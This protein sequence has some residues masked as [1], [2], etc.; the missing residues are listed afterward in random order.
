MA[1]VRKKAL[2]NGK[3]Q[4]YYV[5]ATGKR[6]FFTGTRS[7][8]ETK[9]MAER[10]EDEHRQVRL[11]YRPAPRSADKHRRRPI[12]E[13]KDEY[14]AWGRSQGGRGGRPWSKTHSRNRT[15]R[16]EWWFARLGLGSLVDLDRILPRVEAALRDLQAKGR[17]GKTLANYAEA[18]GAF[19]DWCVQRGY[20]AS[21]PLQGMAS[22]DTTPKTQ[23]RAMTA[24]EIR[25]LLEACDPRRRLLLETAF[26]S[27]LRANELRNL[28][29]AHLDLDRCGLH[30]DADWTKNRKAG[31][32]PLP[33]SLVERLHTFAQSGEPARLYARFYARKDARSEAP[34][35]PLFYVPS[36]TARDL[37]RDLRA[38]RIQKYA[39]GGKLDFHACR[40][41]YINFVIESGVSVKE[42]QA[43][44]RHST[45]DLTLNVYGR[46]RE[47][48]L[49]QVVEEVAIALL[50]EEKRATCV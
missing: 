10:L 3:Y 36:H 47:E 31:F 15:T 4:G 1:G 8:A 50:P 7:R 22:F 45:P 16:L 13:I 34:E 37:D 2:P 38:A 42:V 29:V 27:G 11:G 28:T 18:I 26:L 48:R 33:Q 35:D 19:C 5:D 44:A 23:R 43:L 24:D 39:P 49:S 6:R 41:A 30:L 17:A 40:L 9:R 20:L 14:L 12:S 46:A 21:D 25:R 32:Q